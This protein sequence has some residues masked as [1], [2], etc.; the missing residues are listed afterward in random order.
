M[1]LCVLN[2]VHVPG[3]HIRKVIKELNQVVLES[4]QGEAALGG[5]KYCFNSNFMEMFGQ[6]L[7]CV[8]L[9]FGSSSTCHSLWCHISLHML[10]RTIEKHP[11]HE[12]TEQEGASESSVKLCKPIQS[13]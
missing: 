10:K 6:K 1:S 4:K 9:S 2:L 12:K 8:S 3:S 13:E 11:A 5:A 7:N